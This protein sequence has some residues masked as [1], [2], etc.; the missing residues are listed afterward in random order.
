MIA[1]PALVLFAHGARDPA[2]ALPFQK[3]QRAIQSKRPGTVVQLAFLEFM[4]PTLRDAAIQLAA[5]GHRRI[6][7]APLFMSEGGHVKR[8]VPK[9]LDDLR[10]AH[11]GVAIELLP[12]IGET[13]EVLGAI[14]EW[15]ASVVKR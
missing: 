2:W 14:A 5:G 1:D 6:I 4:A 8:D 12:S 7:I 9:L 11:P 10:G 13:E 15:L 3:I